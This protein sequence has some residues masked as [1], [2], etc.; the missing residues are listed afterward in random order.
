MKIDGSEDRLTGERYELE[1]LDGKIAEARTEVQR[2]QS[3]IASH[4]NQIQFNQQRGEEFAE[5]IER[6]CGDIDSAEAKRTEQETQIHEADRLIEKTK[7]LLESKEHELAQWIEKSTQLR[8]RA[9]AT[10]GGS[11]QFAK[12]H[13]EIGSPGLIRGRRTARVSSAPRSDGVAHRGF[14]QSDGG[15]AGPAR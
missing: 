3:E 2:L 11:A 8:D 13:F 6:Y 9:R 1:E 15:R 4:R 5:L 7:R 10:R 14:G 12:F